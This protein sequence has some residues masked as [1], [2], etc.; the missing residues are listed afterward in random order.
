MN[1]IITYE[2]GTHYIAENYSE[3]DFNAVQEGI[4]SIIRVSDCKELNLD[5]DWVELNA[6]PN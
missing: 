2:D 4:I 1:Y 3:G 6:W 5:G